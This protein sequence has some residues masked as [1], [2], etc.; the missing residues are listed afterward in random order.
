[1]LGRTLEDG[2]R[3]EV[4]WSPDRLDR[5]VAVIRDSAGDRWP[6]L[7]LNALVQR[8]VMNADAAYLQ[9]PFD[10]EA[11]GRKIRQALE[12]APPSASK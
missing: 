5:A 6:S 11:L 9:K 12:A 7:E 4:R 1:M 10:A 3:H 2:Q 8:V